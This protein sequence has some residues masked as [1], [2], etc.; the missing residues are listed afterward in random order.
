[1]PHI[2]QARR[3]AAEA[4]TQVM[5]KKMTRRG[6]LGATGRLAVGAGL[7]GGTPKDLHRVISTGKTLDRVNQ[8]VAFAHKQTGGRW[9]DPKWMSG[10]GWGLLGGGTALSAGRAFLLDPWSRA[11]VG[12]AAYDLGSAFGQ[13]LN[14]AGSQGYSLDALQHY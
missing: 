8:A 3:Q 10:F 5:P 7:L 4:V 14:N 9:W 13:G 11:S 1:M 12:D 2:Q 6:F